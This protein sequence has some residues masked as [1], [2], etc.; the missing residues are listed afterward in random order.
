VALLVFIPALGEYLVPE[1]VGGGQQYYLGTFLQQQ[2]QVSR[3]WPLGS[4]AIAVLV[5]LSAIL[6]GLGGKALE[7]N[8]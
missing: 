7:E 8:A 5:L 2:F 6:V 3:N 4:A 1:L